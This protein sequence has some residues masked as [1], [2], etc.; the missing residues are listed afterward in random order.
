MRDT[1]KLGWYKF[2]DIKTI[3]R[4]LYIYLSYVSHFPMGV[5][6]M[7]VAREWYGGVHSPP[8]I[9]K[10]TLFFYQNTGNIVP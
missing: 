4:S 9:F 2:Y 6:V 7:P 8:P 3:R 10:K 1:A 5:V